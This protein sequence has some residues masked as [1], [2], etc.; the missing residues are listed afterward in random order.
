MF[1]CYS[2]A[3]RYPSILKLRVHLLRYNSLGELPIP[4]QC[5]QK[6]CNSVFSKVEK[7]IRNRENFHAQDESYGESVSACVNENTMSNE[8]TGEVEPIHI[9]RTVD[10]LSDI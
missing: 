6:T 10:C 7:L 9:K 5:G 1:I 8:Q 2:C 3:T 4:L